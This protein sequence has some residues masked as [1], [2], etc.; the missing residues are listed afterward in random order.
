MSKPKGEPTID[1]Q[2]CLYYAFLYGLDDYRRGRRFSD[3]PCHSNPKWIARWEAG[4]RA[5]ASNEVE[6]PVEQLALL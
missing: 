6:M 4:Y 2:N 5:A 3:R 1:D